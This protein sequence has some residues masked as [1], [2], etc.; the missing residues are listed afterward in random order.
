MDHSEFS[1]PCKF[2]CG[3]CCMYWRDVFQGEEYKGLDQCP[4]L[5]DDGCELSFEHRPEPC[6]NYLCEIGEAIANDWI[7]ADRA[8]RIVDANLRWEP[9]KWG[10]AP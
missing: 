1:E 10:C 9:G 4:H 2:A 5:R 6:R 8:Q 7:D 3:E